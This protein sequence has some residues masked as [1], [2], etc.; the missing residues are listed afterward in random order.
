MTTLY[1]PRPER[2]PQLSLKGFFVLVTVLGG[3]LG[4]LSVK[5]RDAA[6]QKRAVAAIRSVYGHAIYDYQWPTDTSTTNMQATSPVPPWLIDLL[7][8]DFFHNV[9]YVVLDSPRVSDATLELL[10]GFAQVRFVFIAESHVTNRGLKR[11]RA[12]PKLRWLWISDENID[13]DGIAELA[14]LTR[15]QELELYDVKVTDHGLQQLKSIAGLKTLSLGD[16]KVTEA[17]VA[18]LRRSLPECEISN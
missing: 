5:A 12:L 6:A 13:D 9:V 7:G 3:V 2:W 17:G 15:L 14:K 1:K 8:A 4:W 16:T 11:L 10:D 18:E